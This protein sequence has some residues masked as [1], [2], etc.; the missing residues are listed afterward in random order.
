MVDDE[1]HIIMTVPFAPTAQIHADSFHAAGPVF[2]ENGTCVAQS[3]ERIS[4]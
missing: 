4:A 2:F 1:L 3:A